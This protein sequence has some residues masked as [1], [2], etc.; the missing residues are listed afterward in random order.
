MQNSKDPD[1]KRN[2]QRLMTMIKATESKLNK[3][4]SIEVK[5]LSMAKETPVKTKRQL[6]GEK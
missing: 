3:S 1:L 5:C 4:D 2:L 6:S